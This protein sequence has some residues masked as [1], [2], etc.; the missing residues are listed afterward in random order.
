MIVIITDDGWTLAVAAWSLGSDP[1]LAATQCGLSYFWGQEGKSQAWNV[2][3]HRP[4]QEVL[5]LLR[6]NAAEGICDL[7]PL[8]EPPA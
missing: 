1:T 2:T 7:R 6:A 5:D 4:L 3:L 8:Q